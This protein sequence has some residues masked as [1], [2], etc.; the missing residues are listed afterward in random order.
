MSNYR[1]KQPCKYFQQGRCNKGNACNFAHVHSGG[2]S[3]GSGGGKSEAERYSEFVSDGALERWGNMVSSDMGDVALFQTRPLLSSYAPTDVAAVNLI[4]GRDLSA[5]ESR[6]Q[7]WEAMAQGKKAQYDAAMA[8]RAKD[9]EKCVAYVK[10][11]AK[12]GARFLQ[13]ATKRFREQGTYPSKP[14]IEHELDLTGGSGFGAAPLGGGGA[15]GQAAFGSTGGTMAASAFGQPAFGP[16]PTAGG[17]L[18][19]STPAA[20]GGAFG[21]A[22]AA[23]GGAF[24]QPAFGASASAATGAFGSGSTTTSAFGSPAFGSGATPTISGAFGKPAFGT[25]GSGA[26]GA[27]GKPSFGTGATT[28][29]FGTFG[30]QTAVNAAPATTSNA[31]GQPAFGSAGFG[32]QPTPAFGTGALPAKPFGFGATASTST[33]TA[34]PFGANS[35]G[36]GGTTSAF[37]QPPGAAK[38][39]STFGS[40]PASASIGFGGK[41]P[42]QQA[43]SPFTQQAIGSSSSP[44]GGA[45]TTNTPF[46]SPQQ[47][48]GS[49][50]TVQSTGTTRPVQ[51]LPTADDKI[52]EDEL[53]REILDAFKAERFTLGHIPGVAPPLTLIH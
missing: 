15:F 20:G 39:G 18:F 33:T 52:T 35:S 37:G 30:A 49:A 53:P 47:P 42:S 45:G 29:P 21:S 10:S 43:L 11:N 12:K 5:E 34:V 8:A 32:A 22:P 1:N 31:F 4:Q 17:G 48:F 14:F 25:A 6:F 50:K 38:T 13:L 3:S 41:V 40:A 19:G 28:S 7:W 36:M 26:T 44:F 24:G 2:A 46:G 16:P 27:F 23:G 51:G 9:I